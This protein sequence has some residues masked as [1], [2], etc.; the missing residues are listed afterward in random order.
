MFDC[1][2]VCELTECYYQDCCR[3]SD[4]ATLALY[5]RIK[6]LD[7]YHILYSPI[8]GSTLGKAWHYQAATGPPR[9]GVPAFDVY[10]FEHYELPSVGGGVTTAQLL[11]EY[12][13]DFA[14]CW[15]MGE[16]SGQRDGN[17]PAESTAELSVQD[18]VAFFWRRSSWPTVV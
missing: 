12:P 13:L 7:P 17:F 5:Q 16:A 14:P 2:T 9:G 11:Q 8:T 3:E 10:T 1:L 15:A 6:S 4:A 18:W